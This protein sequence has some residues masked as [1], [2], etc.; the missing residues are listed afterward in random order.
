MN[1]GDGRARYESKVDGHHHDHLIC[2]VCGQ[3]LEFVDSQIEKRQN[4]VAQKYQF[5]LK[6]HIHQLFGICRECQ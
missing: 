4:V 3:I 5:I 1:L 6:R 2:Q